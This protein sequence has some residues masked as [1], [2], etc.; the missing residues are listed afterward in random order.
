MR[1][2]SKILPSAGQPNLTKEKIFTILYNLESSG[3]PQGIAT[4]LESSIGEDVTVFDFIELLQASDWVTS[5]VF[6]GW[7]RKKSKGW[8]GNSLFAQ[9]SWQQRW[10][11]LQ[12]LDLIYMHEEPQSEQI[13]RGTVVRATIGSLTKIM[14]FDEEEKNNP[15]RFSVQPDCTQPLVW[16]FMAESEEEKSN[17][18]IKISQ[19]HAIATWLENYKKVKVLGIGAQG[20]VYEMVHN[21]TGHRCAVK[22]VFIKSDKQMQLALT[23]A[24]LLMEISRKAVHPNLIQMEK[25]FQ[26]D[27][28]FFLVFPL[29]TGG[30]L[31]EALVRRGY[32]TERK[33]ARIVRDLV[34]ALGALHGLGFLHLDVK[35]ENILFES[36]EAYARIKLVDFGLSKVLGESQELH[37]RACP[38]F[39]ELLA[40][41]EAFINCGNFN[42]D[43]VRGTYGYMS[44]EVI[45]SGTLHICLSYFLFCFLALYRIK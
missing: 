30:E 29:C 25:V 10:V 45:L 1:R 39:E 21:S 11:A 12:G 14:T 31:Y 20:T 23:E 2:R 6:A 38:S 26:V 17:W 27:R 5:P 28:T 40:R 7:L 32:F 15:L 34:S 22:E 43:H 16:H 33:A 19:V 4:M 3:T 8:F 13:S 41:S 35:P 24:K 36:N 42:A 44:P 9:Y 18:V 37:N